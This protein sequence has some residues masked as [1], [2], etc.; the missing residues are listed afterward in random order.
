[1]EVGLHAPLLYQGSRQHWKHPGTCWAQLPTWCPLPFLVSI[2]NIWFSDSHEHQRLFTVLALS[3]FKHRKQLYKWW[4]RIMLRLSRRS[5]SKAKIF[6]DLVQKLKTRTFF[7]FSDPS[8]CALLRH[9]DIV[10]N[11]GLSLPNFSF[12]LSFY[13]RSQISEFSYFSQIRRNLIWHM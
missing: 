3:L 11:S 9:V 10:I 5:T 13:I 12:L 8:N 2:I 6:W 7:W 1:M 4:D